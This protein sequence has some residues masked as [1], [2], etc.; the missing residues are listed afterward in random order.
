M[1]RGQADPGRPGAGDQGD[2]R[3]A[4]HDVSALWQDVPVPAQREDTLRPQPVPPDTRAPKPGEAG[5][6]RD[7]EEVPLS[8]LRLHGAVA[9][10]DP[11]ARGARAPREEVPVQRVPT[12]V[13]QRVPARAARQVDARRREDDGRVPRVRPHAQVQVPQPAPADL[14]RPELRAARAARARQRSALPE[15]S[16]RRPQHARPAAAPRA[17]TRREDAA[18][19]PVQRALRPPR[20][21]QPARAR[22]ALGGRA[23]AR[24]RRVPALPQGDAEEEPGRAHTQRAREDQG[25][26]V[27]DVQQGVPDEVHAALPPGDTQEALGAHLQV[28]V[29]RVWGKLQ[30][31]DGVSRPRQHA[32]RQPAVP[33]R[34]LQQG[35]QANLDV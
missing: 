16:V 18:V 3:G 2:G 25:A 11:R 29:R 19:W 1:G 15:V 23:G 8:A 14:P 30:Q 24:H 34:R 35:V 32:H 28:P 33:V 17:P 31:Q 9:E 10:E 21:P 20:R 6:R 13:R 22:H 7:D 5:A 12:Q 26:R 27:R 4:R